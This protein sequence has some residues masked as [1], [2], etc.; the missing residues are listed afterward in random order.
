MVYTA[1]SMGRILEVQLDCSGDDRVRFEVLRELRGPETS[2]AQ[3]VG[4]WELLHEDEDE[5]DE[6]NAARAGPSRRPAYIWAASNDKTAQR[7]DVV[8]PV[9]KAGATKGAPQPRHERSSNTGALLGR[10]PPL[11]PSVILSHPDYVKTVLPL[12]QDAGARCAHVVVTGSADED[13]RVWRLAGEEVGAEQQL[14][15][16][17]R[18]HWHEVEK[19]LLWHGIVDEDEGEEGKEACSASVASWWVI[20]AGLDGS[21]RRWR[22]DELLVAGGEEEEDEDKVEEREGKQAN[23]SENKRPAATGMTAEEE[24]ELAELMSDEE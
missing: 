1:D 12:P 20:S 9:A 6:E 5:D 23:G 10:L 16:R 2:V 7:F 13:L 15:R 17:Q 21:I 8:A 18:G 24:A 19:V 14:V 22:L 11:A 4:C 3:L